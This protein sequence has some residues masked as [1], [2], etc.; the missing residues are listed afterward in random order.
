MLPV[1]RSQIYSIAVVDARTGQ[2]VEFNEAA[3]RNLGYS[4]A[5]FARL[6]VREINCLLDD[7]VLGERLA[8]MN[9]PAGL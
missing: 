7:A 5:E 1:N 8:Q 3:H 2:F 9:T 6:S 4:R